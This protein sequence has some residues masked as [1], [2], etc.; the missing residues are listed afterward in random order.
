MEWVLKSKHNAIA[1]L[2]QRKKAVQLSNRTFHILYLVACKNL[3]IERKTVACDVIS[4]TK[5][6]T[7]FF[8]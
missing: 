3:T 7:Y 2:L 6:M 8:V 4:L 5:A 1:F